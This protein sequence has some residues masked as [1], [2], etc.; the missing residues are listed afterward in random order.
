M[1][2]AESAYE[3]E[4]EGKPSQISAETLGVSLVSLVALVK[5]ANAEL[6]PGGQ[7]TIQIKAQRE[8]SYILG[9]DLESAIVGSLAMVASHEGLLAAKVVGSAVMDLVKKVIELKRLLTSK[10]QTQPPTQVGS[11]Y[12]FHFGDNAHVVIDASTKH[13]FDAPAAQDAMSGLFGAVGQDQKVTG[14]AIKEIDGDNRRPLVAIDRSE[15]K[16]LAATVD[17]QAV[18]DQIRVEAREARLSI[19]KPSL[20]PGYKWE[21]VYDGVRIFAEMADEDYIGK[22][23]RREVVFGTGDILDVALEIEQRLL[24]GTTNVYLNRSF[25][26]VKVHDRAPAPSQPPLDLPPGDPDSN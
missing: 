23:E 18:P 6:Y 5:E 21:L 2:T 24:A 26:I 8:G 19:L 11:N 10:P 4:F 22:V 17:A 20:L 15:F 9:Y 13:V 16:A 3:I 14:L 7:I 25:R 12:H 1:P